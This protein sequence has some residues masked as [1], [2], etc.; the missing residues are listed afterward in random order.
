MKFFT[1]ISI[2]LLFLSCKP[3]KRIITISGSVYD[4]NLEQFIEDVEITAYTQSS[5]DGTFSYTFTK[6]A[7]ANSDVAGQFSFEIPFEYTLAYRLEFNKTNYFSDIVEFQVEVIPTDDHYN[8]DYFIYPE[9]TIR[10]HIV[11]QYPFDENDMIKYRIVDWQQQCEGCCYA[12]FKELTGTNINETDE[13]TLYGEKEYT[14][15]YLTW[16][17]G[18]QNASHKIVFCPAFETTNVEIEF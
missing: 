10:I 6:F 14:V 3:D 12:G 2:L 17:N 18:N 11:N 4:P 15:E 9:T 7:T 5:K 13:C 8:N 16:K 1:F